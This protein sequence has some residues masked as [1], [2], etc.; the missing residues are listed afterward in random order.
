[1]SQPIQAAT[2]SRWLSLIVLCAGQMMIILDG[3]I[4]NVAL[5]VIQRDLGFTQANLAWVV[6]IYMI[7]FG[8]LLLLGGRLGDLI[9]RKRM[10]VAGIALFTAAS[11]VCGLSN[12]QA[13]LLSA[14]FVQGIGGAMSSA[15]ILGMI[16]VLFPEDNYRTRAIGVFSF[17]SASGAAIGLLAGGYLTQDLSWHWVFFVNVPIGIAACILGIRLFDGDAGAGIRDGADVLGAVL[18]IAG[19]MLLVYSVIETSQYG[20]GSLHTLGLGALSILLLVAFF[21][22]Q[23]RARVPV[24]P[25]RIF[26]VRAVTGANLVQIPMV[27]GMFGFQLMGALYLEHVLGYS[28]SSTG[29]AYLPTAVVIAVFALGLA[30]PLVMRFGA[31][32]V[33]VVGL[34]LTLAALAWLARVPVDGHYATDVLPSMILLG[35]GAGLG[36]PAVT[37]LAMSSASPSDA[38]IA[39]G[40]VNTTQQVGGALGLA[41]VVSLAS[42]RTNHQ[43]A[44]GRS[45]PSA[46][47]DGYRLAFTV[48]AAIVLGAIVLALTVLQGQKKTAA[49]SA[50]QQDEVK[51]AVA[52]AAE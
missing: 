51:P 24:L 41:I 9:G 11:L 30:Q 17:V 45:A 13:M 47:T 50:P 21:F 23:T 27:I 37:M 36:L 39:S 20:W 8:S 28:P 52:S 25:L 6:D 33:L 44:I 1:M 48:A 15:V 38:G 31:R 3:S 14:R 49:A 22:R 43:L 7:S 19:L 5:P 46:L 42:E 16:V 2:R 32:D 34:V 4:L 35:A 10:F 12:S 40:L 29:L 26:R 18:S